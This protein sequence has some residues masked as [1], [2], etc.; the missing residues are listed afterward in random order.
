MHEDIFRFRKLVKILTEQKR[1][2]V[3]K[4]CM[5]VDISTATLKKLLGFPPDELKPQASVLGKVQNFIKKHIID[6]DYPDLALDAGGSITHTE[7]IRLRVKPGVMERRQ[8]ELQERGE[9]IG[10]LP[11][12]KGL[13]P[14]EKVLDFWGYL[15]AALQTAPEHVS[16]TV[17]IHSRI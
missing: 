5:E 17:Q 12:V 8:R 16:I 1:W 9:L 14:P 13:D 15:N 6:L 2:T 4:V 3:K 10:E 7:Q 11:P